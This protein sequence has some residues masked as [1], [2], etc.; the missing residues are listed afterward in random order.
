MASSG[1]RADWSAVHSLRTSSAQQNS[2]RSSAPS[3]DRSNLKHLLDPNE[4]NVTVFAQTLN[5][6]GQL[7]KLTLS[8]S[9]IHLLN[10]KLSLNRICRCSTASRIEEVCVIK[11]LTLHA[12]RLQE[13]KLRDCS[14]LGLVIVHGESV[15]RLLTSDCKRLFAF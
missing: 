14:R 9:I 2:T 3:T 11:K 1:E 5:S 6:F 8:V 10:R 4:V 15:E 13:V 12:P 7:E